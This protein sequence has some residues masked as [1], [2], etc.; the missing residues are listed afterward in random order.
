MAD[1]MSGTNGAFTGL[2]DP[3]A[4]YM[5]RKNPNGTFRGVTPGSGTSGLVLNDRP[6]NFWGGAFAVATGTDANSRYVFKNGMPWPVLTAAE[7]H[8][9]LAEAQYR[10]G[11]ASKPDALNSYRTGISRN[12][13]MLTAV[14]EAGVPSGETMSATTKTTFLANPLLVPTLANFNLSHIMLQ[15]YIALYAH[16]LIETWVDMRRYH[17]VDNEQ[18]TGLQVYRDFITPTVYINNNGKL[19]YRARPRYN[20]EFL[21]NIEALDAIGGRDLDYHTKEMW[22]SMP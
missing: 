21:Y 6:E 18:A 22:F 3:R 16:G 17:Y 8:F 11:I 4:I 7:T 20:S 10:K 1:L 15:K 5:L 19:V 14:Y 9:L 2:Q 13:D 12:L